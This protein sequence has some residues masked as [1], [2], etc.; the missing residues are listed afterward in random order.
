MSKEKLKPCEFDKN[1]ICCALACYSS[2]E[3]GARDKDGNPK[4]A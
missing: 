4:Y 2:E 3:C 1:G